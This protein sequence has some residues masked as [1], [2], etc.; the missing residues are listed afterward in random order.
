MEDVEN[1]AVYI[2]QKE[3][4]SYRIGDNL[5]TNVFTNDKGDARVE[6][7]ILR[8]KNFIKQTITNN[9]NDIDYVCFIFNAAN[10]FGQEL[11]R[12][13]I[14]LFLDANKVFD[15]F[16]K[17]EYEQRTSSWSGSRVPI[18]EREKTHLIDILPLLN[19]VDFLEHRA[20]VE[21]QI[22]NKIKH[23]ESEKK[24]DYLESRE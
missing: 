24:R 22:E 6:E 14:E 3:E 17:I 5:F 11:I 21:L 13:L 19:S 9:I 23:I 12:E 15:D 1:Y 8:K 18:L 7:L 16:K 4:N 20:Y 10:S 2:F